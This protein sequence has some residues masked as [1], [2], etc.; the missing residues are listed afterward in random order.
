MISTEAAGLVNEVKLRLSEPE[1]LPRNPL[2]VF[3]GCGVCILPRPWMLTRV[4]FPMAGPPV[5][6]GLMCGL[7]S[8]FDHGYNFRWPSRIGNRSLLGVG[9]KRTP[10]RVDCDRQRRRRGGEAKPDGA[11]RRCLRERPSESLCLGVY[12]E[13]QFSLGFRCRRYESRALSLMR[14]RRLRCILRLEILEGAAV[15]QDLDAS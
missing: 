13:N 10:L 1:M 9:P 3:S 7:S 8:S 2:A 4:L 11:T 6:R 15:N 14:S 12:L 5:G